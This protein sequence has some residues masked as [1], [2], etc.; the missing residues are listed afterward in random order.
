MSKLTKNKQFLISLLVPVILLLSMTVK[1]LLTVLNGETINLQTTP[2]DPS[3]IVYGDY[4][5]LE[6]KIETLP[7]TIL[8]KGL[9]KKL[10][11]SKDYFDFDST[12][13]IYIELK[14]NKST[15][16]SEA[17][18]VTETKPTSGVFIKGSLSSYVDNNQLDNG[19]EQKT[20]QVDIP[21]DRYYVEDNTGTKLEEQARKGKV[22]M[23]VRVKNGYAILTGVSK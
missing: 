1:P 20:I 19:R 5:S 21:L 17:T 16:I 13:P 11:K 18:K 4:V 14:E 8:D 2:I 15:G 12:L 22:V 7:L 6:F 10:D 3:D 9:E 23:Q